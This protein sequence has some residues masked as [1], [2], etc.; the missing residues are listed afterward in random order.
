ML[1]IRSREVAC[2]QRSGVRHREDALQ[3]LDF[4]NG[5][6]SIHPFQSSST[7]REG[8]FLVLMQRCVALD[9]ISHFAGLILH[10]VVYGILN[11]SR[12]DVSAATYLH[13][14]LF[15]VARL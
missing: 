8:V 11:Q 9:E 4:S 13:G 12:L 14:S 10:N 3:S 5:L 1:P 6:F 7:N 2:A 15:A